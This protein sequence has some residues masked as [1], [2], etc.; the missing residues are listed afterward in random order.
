MDEG[1]WKLE[2]LNYP[3]LK[4]TQQGGPLLEGIPSK[5]DRYLEL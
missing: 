2:L 5:L 1:A 4:L 3:Y